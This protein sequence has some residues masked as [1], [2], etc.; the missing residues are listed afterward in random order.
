VSTAIFSLIG[1]VTGALLQ[2]YFTRYLDSQK[3]QRELRTRAYTDYLKCVSEHANLTKQRSSPEGRELGAKTADAK[4]RVCLYGSSA[5]IE[6]FAT[7][8]KLGAAMNTQEQ[9]AAF[10]LMVSTMRIDS[11]GAGSV[12]LDD[13]Q[14]VLLGTPRDTASL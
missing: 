14:L 10:T 3:H 7:F 12:K 1:I 2:F 13:L 8:E 11:M 6:A 5:A 4:C 9:C